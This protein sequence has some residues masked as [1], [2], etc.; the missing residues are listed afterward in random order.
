MPVTA[1]T[2]L[3]V[4]PAQSEVRLTLSTPH[5]GVVLEDEGPASRSCRERDGWRHVSITRAPLAQ[6]HAA[7]PS[8]VPQGK[9]SPH[10]APMQ[11]RMGVEREGNLVGQ[12]AGA[13]LGR[14]QDASP[15]FDVEED[16]GEV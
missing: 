14:P 12:E 15:A 2:Y 10:D 11:Q 1:L 4:G 5:S 7:R 16:F 13:H 8:S 6:A 3:V 9:L